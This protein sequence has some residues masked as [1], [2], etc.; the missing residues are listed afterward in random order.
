M[1]SPQISL[2]NL[3]V[4]IFTKDRPNILCGLLQ[5]WSET[6]ASVIVLDASESLETKNL[7]RYYQARYFWSESFSERAHKI[8][9]LL[10]TDF[11]CINMDDDVILKSG[12]EKAIALLQNQEDLI[13]AAS[14]RDF[15]EKHFNK[16]NAIGKVR[17]LHSENDLIKRI[18]NWKFTDLRTEY[19]WYAIW[20]AAPFI[21]AIEGSVPPRFADNYANQFAT[22]GFR[23]TAAAMGKFRV[24]PF[25]I[26]LKRKHFKYDYQSIKGNNS[27]DSDVISNKFSS[28][29]RSELQIDEWCVNAAR[30]ISSYSSAR[31]KLIFEELKLAWVSYHEWEVSRD[32]SR[33]VEKIVKKTFRRFI[34]KIYLLSRGEKHIPKKNKLL[35]HALKPILRLFVRTVFVLSS[36]ATL[37]RIPWKSRLVK[38]N[39]DL[40]KFRDSGMIPMTK[41]KSKEKVWTYKNLSPI[42]EYISG[43]KYIESKNRLKEYMNVGKNG[44]IQK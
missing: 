9:D 37:K 24:V 17:H 11:A 29:E 25:D 1:I 13:G 15:N 42:E 23:L 28:L 44:T 7:S 12:A 38:F 5:Y 43:S 39:K 4:V 16:R 41:S 26:Y 22:V 20:R 34:E 6:S 27:V 14:V 30:R 3:S 8:R 2:S 31:E 10:E 36:V 33:T 40:L 18:E 35:E 32:S 21:V 19:P